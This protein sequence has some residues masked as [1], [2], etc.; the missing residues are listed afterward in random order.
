MSSRSC[1]FIFERIATLIKNRSEDPICKTNLIVA[2]TALLDQWKME[3]EM[4]TNCGLKCLIYHGQRAVFLVHC[5]TKM[6]IFLRV[7]QA[8]EK[9]RTIEI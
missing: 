1:L 4:K 8:K 6:H 3:I 2:P 5:E 9:A 7:L